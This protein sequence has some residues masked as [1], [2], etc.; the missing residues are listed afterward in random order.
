MVLGC[1][2]YKNRSYNYNEEINHHVFRAN[3]YVLDGNHYDFYPNHYVLNENHYFFQFNGK[4]FT[5]KVDKTQRLLID[6]ALLH[7][8]LN[9]NPN[10]QIPKHRKQHRSSK[11]C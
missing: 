11:A 4:T 10:Q 5:F 9:K 8:F 1:N 7:N 6:N 2:H 3:H